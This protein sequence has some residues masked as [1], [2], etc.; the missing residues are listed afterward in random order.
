MDGGGSLSGGN[1]PICGE[2]EKPVESPHSVNELLKRFVVDHLFVLSSK[3]AA[4]TAGTGS[5]VGEGARPGKRSEGKG[6]AR[7]R[8]R[9]GD[10]GL[11]RREKD[12]KP[13][14]LPTVTDVRS[15]EVQVRKCCWVEELARITTD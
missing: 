8:G 11:P 5:G 4:E 10:G 6:G 7:V 9:A 14:S 15:E 12:S 2:V 1:A 3:L 13:A